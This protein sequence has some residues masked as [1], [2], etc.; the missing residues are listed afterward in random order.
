MTTFTFYFGLRL[1]QKLYGMTGNLSKTFQKEKMS[2]LSAKNLSELSNKTIQRMRNDKVFLLFLEAVKKGASKIKMIE[3]PTLSRKRKQPNYS[4]LTYIEGH[5][6]GKEDYHP[7]SL[8]DYFKQIYFDALDSIINAIKNWF[9][10]PGYQIFSGVEQLLLKT[11]SKEN[12][13][14]ELRRISERYS[15]DFG[16]LVISSELDLLLA[17][18]EENSPCNFEEVE[19][20]LQSTPQHQRLLCNVLTIIRL[21]LTNGSTSATAE[22]SFSMARRMKTWLRLTMTQKQFNSLAVLNTH[23]EIL[24]E[25]SLLE[26]GNDFVDGRPN[27]R[28]EFGVFWRLI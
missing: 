21:V 11:I 26:V 12:H 20:D 23:K 3:K 22:L 24:D 14:D 28:N 15:S 13:G 8:V 25:L 10:Q 19:R 6:N 17:I 18:F 2:A 1:G 27:R 9:G 4:I 7:Y 16:W 5:E